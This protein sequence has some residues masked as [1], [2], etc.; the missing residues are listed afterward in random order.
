MSKTIKKVIVGAIAVIVALLAYRFF[1]VGPPEP[2]LEGQANR[3]QTVGRE[4]LAL[5]N[6][7]RSLSL[8]GDV[9]ERPEFASL[10]DFSV[11]ISPNPLGRRNPF[12]PIGV[13]NVIPQAA[14][15]EEDAA[16]EESLP[17]EEIPDDATDG[18]E[19]SPETPSD[20]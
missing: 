20:N 19:E 17:S 10:I 16:E 8:D 5:L 2:L 15:S 11:P 12:A 7:L 14:V 1:F 9:F 6:T 4:L 13:G 3:S 18:T